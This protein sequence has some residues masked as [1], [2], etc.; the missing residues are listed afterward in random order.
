MARI[1][2]EKEGRIALPQDYSRRHDLE[3]GTE[4]VFK[5]IE[6]RLALRFAWPNAH[7]GAGAGHDAGLA[8]GVRQA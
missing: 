5:P 4:L 6:D 1:S 3:E 2:I 8:V 7:R